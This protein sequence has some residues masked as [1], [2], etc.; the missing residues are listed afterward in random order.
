M[1]N[2]QL[3]DNI[4][5]KNIKVIRDHHPKYGDTANY[6]TLLNYELR[7]CQKHYPIFF[8]KNTHSGQ[9]ETIALF[10]FEKDE[11]LYLDENGWHAQYI[12]LTVQ[13][14]PFLIGFQHDTNDG[15][16]NNEPVVH[17]DM[18]S[19]RVNT[20]QGE[21]I[22]MPSGGHSPFLEQIS[23]ILSTINTGHAHHQA[24]IQALLKLDLIESVSINITL[25]NQTT[26]DLPFLYTIYEEKLSQLNAHDL[27]SLHRKSYLQDIY[28]IMA[29]T[30]NMSDLIEKKNQLIRTNKTH[31]S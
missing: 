8:H 6:T 26:I 18:D 21:P 14:R 11:N 27:H 10:G 30:S 12:P 29:S 20:H 7:Q 15:V 5:H 4:T 17:I 9:F 2:H 13:R 25:D 24:F 19:A 23:S 16:V 22:F 3:L 31:T 28:M 1:P